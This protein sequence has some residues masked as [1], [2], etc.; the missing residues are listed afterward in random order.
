MKE[1]LPIFADLMSDAYRVILA[2]DA[3]TPRDGA[4]GMALTEARR[5][6][7]SLYDYQ[8]TAWLTKREADAVQNALDVIQARLKFF[9]ESPL[10]H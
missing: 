2:L 7:A 9:G 3:V 10:V 8:R 4:A 5:V 1:D 6:Y